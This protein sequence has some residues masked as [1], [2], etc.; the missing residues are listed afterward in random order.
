MCSTIVAPKIW[1]H[2]YM[3]SKLKIQVACSTWSTERS[4]KLSFI[5][6]EFE[7]KNKDT[8]ENF[9][10]T[11][12]TKCQW[13]CPQRDCQPS[14]LQKIDDDVLTGLKI[15]RHSFASMPTYEQWGVRPKIQE[16]NKIEN[17]KNEVDKGM[18]ERNQRRRIR[19]P[20]LRLRGFFL[21]L[22]SL[23]IFHLMTNLICQSA[24]SS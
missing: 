13:T 22:L 1:T 18:S 2:S 24:S 15:S 8:L 9:Q 4:Q 17:P 14:G 5:K 6:F 11:C 7:I 19:R 21:S 23:S 12:K 16:N 3:C 20:L 10:L